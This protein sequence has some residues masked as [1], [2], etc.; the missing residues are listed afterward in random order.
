MCYLSKLRY[1][2]R[3]NKVLPLELCSTA[4]HVLQFLTLHK[5]KDF[6]VALSFLFWIFLCKHYHLQILEPNLLLDFQ[7]IVFNSPN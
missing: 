1:V 6:T 7:V 4:K 2:C 5:E 3:K